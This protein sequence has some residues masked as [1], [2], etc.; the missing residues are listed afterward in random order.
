VADAGSDKTVDAGAQVQLDGSNSSD[1]EGE[2]LTYKWT[3]STANPETVTLSADNVVNPGFS[4][5]QTAGIYVFQLVVN[6]GSQDSEMDE[7]SIT[8]Q[9][10]SSQS[11]EVLIT[12]VPRNDVL[13]QS[14]AFGKN[15]F[16]AVGF[17]GNSF[18]DEDRGSINYSSDGENWTEVANMTGGDSW[19]E[20]IFANNRF[21]ATGND[22]AIATSLDGQ[23]WTKTYTSEKWDWLSVSYH[24]G[25]YIFTSKSARYAISKQ[26]DFA[27]LTIY[28]SN[29][30]SDVWYC[31]T[32]HNNQFVMVGNDGR[33]GH[34]PDGD[35]W[36]F[37]T[38]DKQNYRRLTGVTYGNE[39][40]VAT[41]SQGS[42]TIAR[43]NDGE[44]WTLEKNSAAIQGGKFVNDTY[45][46]LG[47]Y[48]SNKKIYLTKDM[49]LANA[50]KLDAD[51]DW[52]DVAFGNNT[53]VIVGSKVGVLKL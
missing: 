36:T 37:K 40:Y 6:D 1:K 8:V 49:D 33:I 16:V 39:G 20:V 4:A 24:A 52:H 30:N 3:V 7:V 9:E 17:Y 22:G 32:H 35:N 53:Y 51:G 23:N 15:T 2:K 21:I 38:I 47:A 31:I 28:K 41:V 11:K 44:N 46:L 18:N 42:T 45:V 26:D 5:P 25:T 43:S 10:V 34:S 12:D 14:V 50:E 48:S 27:D 13:L 19:H 29:Y